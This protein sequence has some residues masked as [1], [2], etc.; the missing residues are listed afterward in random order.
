M[1]CAWFTY[2]NGEI[3]R[4]SW[5]SGWQIWNASFLPIGGKARHVDGLTPLFYDFVVQKTMFPFN[6]VL[7]A[8]QRLP[9]PAEKEDTTFG[10]PLFLPQSNLKA[11][12]EPSLLSVQNFCS[13]S[14]GGKLYFIH[15]ATESSENPTNNQGSRV[16]GFKNMSARMRLRK[17]Q[18]PEQ[19]ALS[20]VSLWAGLIKKDNLLPFV[21][22]ELRRF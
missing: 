13:M 19:F 16:I 17:L 3:P 21:Y 18:P 10:I 6:Y 9:H 1:Q 22:E 4:H 14:R 5:C 7:N 12:K 2:V 8:P 20:F 15:V 11:E